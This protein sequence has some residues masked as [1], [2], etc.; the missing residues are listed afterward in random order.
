MRILFANKK[1]ERLYLEGK[2]AERYPDGVYI[3][4]VDLVRFITSIPDER[5][6]YNLP[7][8][9]PEKLHGKR[10]FEKSLRLNQQFRLI[11]RIE[12]DADGN[13]VFILDLED[14]H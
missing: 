14:Y 8:L 9:R 5:I 1:L 12:K 11:Y 13:F 6:L 3:S 2:G 7:G 4:F 10:K